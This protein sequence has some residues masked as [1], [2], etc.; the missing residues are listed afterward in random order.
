MLKPARVDAFASA[1]VFGGQAGL[2]QSVGIQEIADHGGGGVGVHHRQGIGF[3]GKDGENVMVG[4]VALGRARTAIAG[5]AEIGAALNG[6]CGQSRPIGAA[7]PSRQ[8]G[9]G[10]GQVEGQPMPPA[11]AGGGVGIVHGHGKAFGAG[12]GILPGQGRRGIAAGAAEAVEHERL[13]NFTPGLHVGAGHGEIGGPA[14]GGCGQ[15]GGK[16]NGE[17]GHADSP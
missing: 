10:G 16:D 4:L 6:A 17:F 12:R 5:S 3:Q 8:T 14:G 11:A 2:G 9:G 13:G 7:R 15:Q 1:P